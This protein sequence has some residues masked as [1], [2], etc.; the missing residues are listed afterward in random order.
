MRELKCRPFRP[1][2]RLLTP[3]SAGYYGRRHEV[4][5]S[6]NRLKEREVRAK[7]KMVGCSPLSFRAKCRNATPAQEGYTCVGITRKLTNPTSMRP[8][9]A[10]RLAIPV[11]IFVSL[12]RPSLTRKRKAINH[13]S[14]Q[15]SYKYL[16]TCASKTLAYD[17]AYEPG[18]LVVPTWQ[19]LRKRQIPSRHETNLLEL[20][21][22]CRRA[23]RQHTLPELH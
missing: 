8:S 5:I 22:Y 11:S 17:R 20:I 13:A 18:M 21:A 10:Y 7:A 4:P 15:P 14:K 1:S 16:P 19:F 3:L 9:H 2:S 12:R 23:Y 6:G